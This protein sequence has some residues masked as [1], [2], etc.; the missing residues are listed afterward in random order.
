YETYRT[1]LTAYPET[2]LGTMFHPRNK[3]MLHPTNG[4]EYFIDRNGYAFHYVMEY[5]RTGSIIWSPALE[6]SSD[7]SSSP[8]S[9]IIPCSPSLSSSH[10]EVNNATVPTGAAAAVIASTSSFVN[11]SQ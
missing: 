7:F 1:T 9:S 8:L 4:N 2:L 3:E 5:Y 11:R 10:T 6:N